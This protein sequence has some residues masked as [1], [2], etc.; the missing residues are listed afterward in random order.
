VEAPVGGVLFDRGDVCPLALSAAAAAV[1]GMI[2][3]E[4]VYGVWA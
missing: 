1:G 3:E 4:P 2:V